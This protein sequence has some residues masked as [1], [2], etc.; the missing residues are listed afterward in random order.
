MGPAGSVHTHTGADCV[1]CDPAAA[2]PTPTKTKY[3]VVYHHTLSL[4]VSL[5]PIHWGIMFSL[6]NC[7]KDRVGVTILT[8]I[9]I[10]LLQEQT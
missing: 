5:Y 6:M 9:R 4:S 7:Q 1:A 10:L 3:G 8:Y 2:T